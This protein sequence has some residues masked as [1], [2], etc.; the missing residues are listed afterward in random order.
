M[1]SDE[2]S[3]S[4]ATKQ[5]LYVGIIPDFG[6]GILLAPSD[7]AYAAAFPALEVSGTVSVPDGQVLQQIDHSQAGFE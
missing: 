6:E 5:M 2:A 1:A 3:E 7:R 4:R